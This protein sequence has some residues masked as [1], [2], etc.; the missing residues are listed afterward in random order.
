MR[1]KFVYTSSIRDRHTFMLIYIEC[2][3][4]QHTLGCPPV[5]KP[6]HTAFQRL[7]T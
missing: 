1:G 5:L 3:T 6:S 2:I 7:P 4:F